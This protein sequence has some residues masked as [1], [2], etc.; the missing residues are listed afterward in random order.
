MVVVAV[1]ADGSCCQLLVVTHSSGGKG[2]HT[3]VGEAMGLAVA[4]H[5]KVMGLPSGPAGG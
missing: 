1:V 4:G 2:Q 3:D 5:G